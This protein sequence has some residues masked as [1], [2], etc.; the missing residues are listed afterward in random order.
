MTMENSPEEILALKAYR[1]LSD[2]LKSLGA[3]P[4]ALER[5]IAAYSL[6]GRITGSQSEI[7][8]VAREMVQAANANM[9]HP[10]PAPDVAGRL[11]QL[12]RAGVI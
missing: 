5:D 11:E 4:T 8:A 12:R 3:D 2:E 7:K 1:E 10:P 9:K 6:H